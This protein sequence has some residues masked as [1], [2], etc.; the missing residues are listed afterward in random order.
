MKIL[1]GIMSRDTGERVLDTRPIRT[2]VVREL[3]ELRFPDVCIITSHELKIRMVSR[4]PEG[5]TQGLIYNEKKARAMISETIYGEAIGDL[6]DIQLFIY[7]NY[8][9]REL[10]EMITKLIR[11]M[12]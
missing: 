3:G 6:R 5:D 11:K 9:D 2:T 7:Q 4:L 8:N 10:E 12:S 1:D